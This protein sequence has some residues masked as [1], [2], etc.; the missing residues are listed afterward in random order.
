M[1]G[2]HRADD[3]STD[4]SALAATAPIAD[5]A[6]WERIWRET[7]PDAWL[8]PLLSGGTRVERAMTRTMRERGQLLAKRVGRRAARMRAAIWRGEGEQ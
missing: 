6:D 2:R 5:L 4:P 7:D 8:A 1:I 3:D